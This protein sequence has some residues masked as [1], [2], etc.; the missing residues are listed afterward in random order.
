VTEKVKAEGLKVI[1][2]VKGALEYSKEEGRGHA[3]LGL[4]SESY[5]PAAADVALENGWH[6]VT[7]W[8]SGNRTMVLFR[9]VS[10]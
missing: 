7:I 3:L 5:V 10:P 9:L 1:E 8:P 2:W 4:M 6:V